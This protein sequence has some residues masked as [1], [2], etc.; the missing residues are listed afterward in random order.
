MMFTVGEWYFCEQFGATSCKLLHHTTMNIG[1][2][3]SYL[4]CQKKNEVFY[5]Q[6][7]KLQIFYQTSCNLVHVFTLF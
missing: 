4:L 7:N 3:L 6:N 5:G 2:E 1:A